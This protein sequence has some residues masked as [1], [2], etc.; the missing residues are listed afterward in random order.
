MPDRRD[1]FAKFRESRDEGMPGERKSSSKATDTETLK[2]LSRIITALPEVDRYR[3][4]AL[5]QSIARGDYRVDT[6]AVA[7]K[8]IEFEMAF[9]PA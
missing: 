2:E 6:G 8:L 1:R 3:V 9:V 5:K 4:E 7:R